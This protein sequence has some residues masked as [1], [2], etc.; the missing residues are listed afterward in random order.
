MRTGSQI[1][2]VALV[3]ISIAGCRNVGQTRRIAQSEPSPFGTTVA[4]EKEAAPVLSST[5]AGEEVIPLPAIDY[6]DGV[7]S[8]AYQHIESEELPE[9]LVVP[10]DTDTTVL[11]VEYLVAQVLSVNPDIRSAAATWRAAAQRY[12][13][14]VALDDPMFGFLLG[15]GSWGSNEVDDAYMVEVAQKV[16]WHGKRQLRGNK[17]RAEANAAYHDVSEERLRIAEITRL[18]YFEYYLA[19]RQIDILNESTHLL[20]DFREIA[21]SKYESSSVEQQDVLLIDVELA[22]QQRRLLELTRKEQVSRAR[23][24][25]LLITAPD[26]TLS[27]PPSKLLTDSSLIAAED[28]RGIAISQR[29]ELAA[30]SARIRAQRYELSLACKEFYPDLE[31]VGRYDAFWQVPE[32]DL[33]PMVGMNLNM[34][35]YKDKRYAAVSEARAKIAKEQA[36]YDAKTIE[37]AY[38]VEQTYRRVE[39]SQQTIKLY[40]DSILPTARHSIDAARASYVAGKLDLLRLIESQRQLLDLQDRYYEEIAEYHSRL[41]E[42]E[43]VVGVSPVDISAE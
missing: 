28:L 34:P 19:H 27:P 37:I 21:I 12:P 39:E 6:F 17:A 5:A 15:P 42:L 29:P 2:C 11:D 7:H 25:T 1:L 23:I 4:T 9:S 31:F 26:A 10:D 38:E 22:E 16:P 14:E 3:G 43:R 36:D 30:Q 41:A 32:D 40:E 8:V 24:N 20:Q 33:R 18:A 13:Q 35:I